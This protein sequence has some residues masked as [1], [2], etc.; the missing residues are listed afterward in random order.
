M[1]SG[2]VLTTSLYTVDKWMLSEVIHYTASMQSLPLELM[3]AFYS[4]FLILVR[5]RHYQCIFVARANYAADS[6]KNDFEYYGCQDIRLK[7]LCN[8]SV[9]PNGELRVMLHDKSSGSHSKSVIRS[10]MTLV[11]I[12]CATDHTLHIGHASTETAL[13]KKA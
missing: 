9:L 7:Y 6:K 1:C 4:C 12:D 11:L 5:N 10:Y 13:L 3:G 2:S 8:A